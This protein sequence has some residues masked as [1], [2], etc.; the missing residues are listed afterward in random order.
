[1]HG[2]AARGHLLFQEGMLQV[3]V[4]LGQHSGQKLLQQWLAIRSERENAAYDTSRHPF[5]DMDKAFT[6]HIAKT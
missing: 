6:V 3:D 5:T 4:C 2:K 1:M